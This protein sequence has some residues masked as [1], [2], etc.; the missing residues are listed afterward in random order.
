[1]R[2]RRRCAPPPSPPPMSRRSGPRTCTLLVSPM[3]APSVDSSPP[4]IFA[5]CFPS[6][7]RVHGSHLKF[8]EENRR[9][10]TLV[11]PGSARVDAAPM[12]ALSTQSNFYFQLCSP[13]LNGTCSAY[14]RARA[15]LGAD[16]Q[17]LSSSAA[18]IVCAFSHCL[19]GP[20]LHLA[21]N[22]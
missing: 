9:R 8:M 16:V 2:L 15:F 20:I 19:L 18:S 22:C 1:M 3:A 21:G 17:P 11:N 14:I 10:R 12:A 5:V 7:G 13:P 4:Y 6:L